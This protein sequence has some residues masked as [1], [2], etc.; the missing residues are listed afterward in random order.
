MIGKRRGKTIG[1]A[2]ENLLASF[3]L[4]FSGRQWRL[5]ALYLEYETPH[6]HAMV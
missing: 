2:R 4:P 3:I 6:V 1:C 5:Q